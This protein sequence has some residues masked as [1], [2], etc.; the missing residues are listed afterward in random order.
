[1][2]TLEESFVPCNEALTLHELGIDKAKI[3]CYAT[4][5][6]KKMSLGFFLSGHRPQDL[7]AAPTYAQAFD[8]IRTKYRIESWVQPYLSPEPRRNEAKFWYGGRTPSEG[9]SIGIYDT[10]LEAELECLK[11][12]IQFIKEHDEFNI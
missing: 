4:Y 2:R 10:H 11:H 8:F 5:I 3:S 1:M 7:V 9:T 6:K 12:L